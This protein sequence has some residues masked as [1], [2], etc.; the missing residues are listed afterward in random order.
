MT[1]WTFLSID[2]LCDTLIDSIPSCCCAR[3]RCWLTSK[4]VIEIRRW[5]WPSVSQSTWLS[6]ESAIDCHYKNRLVASSL[7]DCRR[8]KFFVG[9][10][11]GSLIM[12]DFPRRHRHRH[13]RGCRQEIGIGHND[14]R[15]PS[16]QSIDHKSP[17]FLYVIVVV[18]TACSDSTAVMETPSGVWRW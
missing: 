12:I 3:C 5:C 1:Y 4:I 8:E 2:Q 10:K 17:L 9:I 15:Q 11:I 7:Q 14:Q 18:Y 13:C 16:I 6:N